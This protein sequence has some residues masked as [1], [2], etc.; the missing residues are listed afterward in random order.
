MN[1]AKKV[2]ITGAGGNIGTALI[3]YLNEK[4]SLTLGDK[5]TSKLQKWVKFGHEIIHLDI[6]DIHACRK[7]CKGIDT[8]IHLAGDPSP[9]AN[10]ETV[11][12]VN[13][14]G[15]YHIFKAAKEENCQR[16][17]FASSAQAVEGYP[18]DTQ[19][20]PD[21]PVR[22]KNLY[23]VGK[24]F[25]EALAAYF[26][27]QE[28][29]PSIAIRIG[30][31]DAVSNVGT[32]LTARDMSAYINPE[33]MCHLI[34]QCILTDLQSPFEIIHAVSNNRFKRLDISKT[35]EVFNYRPQYDGFKECGFIFKD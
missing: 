5:D 27:Y 22:P 21:M 34:E 4:F 13:M 31:F 33:D 3:P 16:V 28:K 30:A 17:I 32:D 1:S 29:L 18:I 8:V 12:K 25:G 35:E 19:V 24:S 20:Q 23:G 7:A 9:H 2:L 15:T 14:E 6:R 10:F 11:L 26:A